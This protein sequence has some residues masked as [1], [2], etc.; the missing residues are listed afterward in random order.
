MLK[1]KKGRE[2]IQSIP[3]RQILIETDGSYSKYNNRHILPE[4]IPSIYRD[5]EFF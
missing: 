5:F 3:T 2:I 1:T 4:G